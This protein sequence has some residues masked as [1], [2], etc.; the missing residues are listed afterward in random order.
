MDI[1]E[2][3][4]LCLGEVNGSKCLFVDGAPFQIRGGEIKN[5][6]SANAPYMEKY[7]WPYVSGLELNTLLVPVAWESVEATEGGY[8]FSLPAR[9]IDQAAERGMKLVFLWFGLWKNGQSSYV[10]IWMK[11]RQDLYFRT[12]RY[13]RRE[14]HVPICSISPLCDSAVERDAAAFAALMAFLREYDRQKTVIAVQVENEVGLLGS[15]RDYSPAAEERFYGAV[16]EEV[17][18]AFG[19]CGTWEQAFGEE[20]CQQ[21]MSWCYAGAV[22]RIA[23]AGKAAYPLPMYVNAWTVQYPGERPGSYPAGGPVM[24]YRRMWR[25]RAPAI[26][27]M[28]PDIYLPDFGGECLKYALEDQALFVPEAVNNCKAASYALYTAGFL[29]GIGFS[30]Y[31]VEHMGGAKQQAAST[32]VVQEAFTALAASQYAEAGKHYLA[33]NTLLQALWGEIVARRGGGQVKSFLDRGTVREGVSL[34]EYDF[35]VTY[36]ESAGGEPAGCGMLIELAPNEFYAAG[37]HCTIEV[38][39]KP[40]RRADAEFLYVDE[41]EVCD[42]RVQ[43][44]RRL[45]G[46]DQWLAFHGEFQIYRFA[47]HLKR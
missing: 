21:F 45:N 36:Q 5:S 12:V 17:A 37:A 7:I 26:E 19:V 14:M 43:V 15:E 2:R 34:S 44:R 13:P 23:A 3:P 33:V 40:G 24:E 11:E 35:R 18:R 16:P 28:S 38:Y 25:L 30:F 22:G 8:D 39:P 41:M 1:Q 29:H 9:I 47:M 32:G 4:I 20:A 27:W 42:G 6:C 31:A 10:P 46:D